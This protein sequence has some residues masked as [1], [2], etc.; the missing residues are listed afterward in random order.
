MPSGEGVDAPAV[1]GCAER[2][3]GCAE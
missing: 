3:A 1:G 2:P